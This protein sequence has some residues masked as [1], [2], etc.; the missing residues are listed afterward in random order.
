MASIHAKPKETI[1]ETAPLPFVEL[2]KEEAERLACGSGAARGNLASPLGRGAPGLG[3]GFA[4]APSVT[5]EKAKEFRW[6]QAARSPLL[7]PV[8]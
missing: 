7:F 1:Q 5:G 6:C 3:L 4:P 8:S 2:Q